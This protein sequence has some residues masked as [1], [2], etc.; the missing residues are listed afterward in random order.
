MHATGFLLAK[1]QRK[2]QQLTLPD[3]AK[4]GTKV[5]RYHTLDENTKKCRSRLGWQDRPDRG[6]RFRQ[7]SRGTDSITRGE[8]RSNLSGGINIYDRPELRRIG[9]ERPR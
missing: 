8:C 2:T 9:V 6:R 3:T 4:E 1:R 5:Q 7:Q